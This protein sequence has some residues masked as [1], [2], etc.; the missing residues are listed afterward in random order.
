LKC[1]K[2]EREEKGDPGYIEGLVHDVFEIIEI[3]RKNPSA[4]YGK[5]SI[6]AILA[7]SAEN[8]EGC[9]RQD[10]QRIRNALVYG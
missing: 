3:Y 6:R 10:S 2:A 9:W 1:L 4:V 8:L 5:E 7:K